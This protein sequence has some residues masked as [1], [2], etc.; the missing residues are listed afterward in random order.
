MDQVPKILKTMVDEWTRDGYIVS[1]KVVSF[2]FDNFVQ[3]PNLFL[4][5][6]LETDPELLIPKARAALERY[7]HQIVIGNDLHRR[8]FEVVF[9]TPNTGGHQTDGS[10]QF[11][12]TWVRIDPALTYPGI[13][14]IKEIEEDIVDELV[15]RHT[16]WIGEPQ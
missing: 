13:Q 8:K 2:A 16:T 10:A 7:G 15:K 9:V 11:V 3:L 4:P 14:Q 1:F 12:E 6:Q 5:F